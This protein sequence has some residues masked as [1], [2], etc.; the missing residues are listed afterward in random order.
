PQLF[1]VKVGEAAARVEK[2]GRELR[3]GKLPPPPKHTFVGRS[4]ELLRVERLLEQENYAVIRGS[5]GLGKTALAAELTRWLVRS[6]RFERAAFVSVEPQ[7]VQDVK[8]VIDSIGR[9][10][11]PKYTVTEFGDDIEA[12]LKPLER[13]LRDLST[14]ILIDN[15]ESVLPDSEGNN[16]AGVADATN[17][18]A[19]GQKLLAVSEHCRLIFT[20]REQLPEPFDRRKN[21][22]QLG[23]LSQDEAIE[24]VE[25]VMAEN[26]WE[27]PVDDNARTAKEVEEL[28][29]TVNRHPRALVLL[30]R[31]VA[32]GVRATTQSVAGLMAELEKKNKGDREN[33]LYASVELSLRRLPAEM[34]EQVNSLAVFHGGGHLFVVAAVLELESDQAQEMAGQ[35]I[36]VGLAEPREYGYLRLDPALPTYLKLDQETERLAELE[37]AW[38]KAMTQLV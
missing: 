34:R 36:G 19:L 31:E 24:L 14:V 22:V 38:A 18:F 11:L 29:N 4:R 3:L 25:R 21:T 13:A 37:M 17:L 20:S 30:A 26:D 6:G 16:P 7:N 2:K 27:P 9:Q 12:A 10:L 32:K 35:L 8:G 33:S 5:G 23:R 28:V 15:M 1:A